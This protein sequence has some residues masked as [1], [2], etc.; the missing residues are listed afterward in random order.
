ME[1]LMQNDK[2][3]HL[4]WLSTFL[5]ASLCS[6]PTAVTGRGQSLKLV[7]ASTKTN[8]SYRFP[9]FETYATALCGTTGKIYIKYY[10]AFVWHIDGTV[11][12]KKCHSRYVTLTWVTTSTC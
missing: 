11:I 7:A 6:F 9:I 8:L 1:I 12:W 2:H 3:P 10:E 4:C 5:Y